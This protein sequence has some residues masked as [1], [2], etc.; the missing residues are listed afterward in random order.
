MAAAHGSLHSPSRRLHLRDKQNNLEFLIDSGS[1]FSVLPPRRSRFGTNKQLKPIFTLLG[2]DNSPINSYGYETLTLDLGFP[3]K[4]SWTFIIADV[5]RPILG[6]D[7]LYEHDLMPDLRRFHLVKGNDSYVKCTA[8]NSKTPSIHMLGDAN[9]KYAQLLKSYPALVRPAPFKETPQHAVIHYIETNGPPVYSKPRRLHP[10]L[11]KKAKKEFN[12]MLRLGIIRYS[13]SPWAS[14]LL[15]RKKADNEI[16]P[17]GDYRMLNKITTPDQYPLPNLNDVPPKLTNAKIFS[18]VDLVKAFHHLPVNPADIEKTAITTPFGLFEYLRMPFGLKNA[19][20]TYQRFM[21][22]IFRDFDFVICYLDDILIFSE[23]EE[24]HLLH[25][26]QVF[27]RLCEYGLTINPAKC[28]LGQSEVTFLGRQISQNGIVP[29]QQNVDRILSLPLPQN[30]H[31]L[32]QT[33]GSF[34][35]YHDH[36]PGA[37]TLLAPLNDMIKGHPKR[38][39]KT[40]VVWNDAALEAFDKCKT[41][42]A[43]SV[44]L[45]IPNL[46][47]PFTLT[48]DASDTGIGA[49]LEQLRPDGVIEPLGFFSKKLDERQQRYPTYDRELLAIYEGLQH[50]RHLVEG[51]PNFVIYTDHQ[52]LTFAL[53][54]QP[55][56]HKRYNARR[57]AHL[58][59]ISQITT[60]IKHVSGKSNIVAD[61]LSRIDAISA[62][63]NKLEIALAQANCPELKKWRQETETSPFPL[64]GYLLSDAESL[65][66]WCFDENQEKPRPYIPEDLRFSIFKQIHDLSHPGPNATLRLLKKRYIW[67]G[68]KEQIRQWTKACDLCQ[69]TKISRHTHSQYKSFP[70]SEKFEKV[71]VDIVGPLPESHGNKYLLTMI[72]RYTRWI[73]IIPISDMAAETVAKTF[74]FNWI[75]RYGVPQVI[76]TD[77]GT[78]F[79]SE[80]HTKLISLLGAKHITTTAYHPSSNG[81]IERV[82]R[83]LKQALTCHKA[84][85]TEALPVVL[86]G[87]RSV[88]REDFPYSPAEAIFGQTL[89]L[90]GEFFD[91]TAP[92]TAIPLPKY[93]D[94]LKTA[95]KHF[96]PAPFHHK[97]SRNFFIHPKLENA[98]KVYLRTDRVKRPLEVSYT[99]PFTVLKRNSKVFTLD[100]NGRPYTVSIDRLKPA[101]YIEEPL[102]STMCHDKQPPS[103]PPTQPSEK[104]DNETSENWKHLPFQHTCDKPVLSPCIKTRLGRISR[105][106]DRY[107]ASIKCKSVTW[108]KNLETIQFI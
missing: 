10:E 49:V 12:E 62:P 77:R 80:L 63:I 105:K 13:K 43:N 108:A 106:P 82:H 74:F 87:L 26:K 35:F 31:Q 29:K 2:A 96:R 51:H 14:P 21:D 23:N 83:Q 55:V 17:C 90:P 59:E 18:V 102:H 28:Q 9:D 47:L 97:T 94:Q 72:D 40:P 45:A 88:C 98:E 8:R 78:Q 4:F 75:S 33:I 20:K 1:D 34:S 85:W 68:M 95:F 69:K 99:G 42:L 30:V 36:I 15:L 70:P 92:D 52:P 84:T 71:H 107:V 50:F 39:D 48:T 41:L 89:R 67:P 7:F 58:D 16:R 101:F 57:A 54:K 64:T 100:V 103:P 6:A 37:A 79:T 93:I 56:S 61:M 25:L 104:A 11:Y 24:Q 32:R 53:S 3:E 65:T 73:E 5:D 22:M 66:I 44:R 38:R 19:P 91:E 81:I 86:L 27:D 60:N 46:S 76:T